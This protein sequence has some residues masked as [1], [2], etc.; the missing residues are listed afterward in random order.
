LA[1]GESFKGRNPG[2]S[3]FLSASVPCP[4]LSLE[5]TSVRKPFFKKT[6]GA[7]YFEHNGKQIRLGKDRDEAFREYHR[8][9]A[10]DLPVTSRTTVA[11]LIDQFLVWVK[12]N[13]EPRTYEWYLA[14]CNRFVNHIGLKLRVSDKDVRQKYSTWIDKMN[15]SDTHRNGACRAVCRAF[16]WAAKR[17]QIAGNPLAGLERPAAAVRDEYLTLAQWADLLMLVKPGGFHDLISFMWETG[18]RPQE[19]RIVEAKHYA[20]GRLILERKNSKGKKYRRVIRLNERARAIVERRI[21]EQGD[22][23]IFRTRYGR[24]WAA[25]SLQCRFAKLSEKLGYRVIPYT[26]RHSW[27]THALLRGVDPLTVGILAGHRDATCVLRVYSHVSQDE[28]FL[29]E[30]LKQATDT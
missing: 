10:G 20:D 4:N 14:H 1:Y 11:Q 2:L 24:G 18:V 16:N 26:I 22:G 13:K 3:V 28:N 9:M 23:V 6:H 29:N 19:A 7:W 15:G 17:G 8:L 30:K 27:I 5:D 12:Q 21:E 25:R